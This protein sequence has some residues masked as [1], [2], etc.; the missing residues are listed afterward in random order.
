VLYYGDDNDEQLAA[1]IL[2]LSNDSPR[3]QQQVSNAL[4]YVEDHNWGVEKSEYLRI[5]DSLTGKLANVQPRPA[6]PSARHP[7]VLVSKGK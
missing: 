7:G 2:F 5:V 4:Q 6:A 3:R 1:N